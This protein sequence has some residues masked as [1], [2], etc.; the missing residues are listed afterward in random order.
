MFKRVD[1]I[2]NIA[3]ERLFRMFGA[4][5]NIEVVAA[6]TRELGENLEEI[7]GLMQDNFYKYERRMN[8]S[9][10]QI[11]NLKNLYNARKYSM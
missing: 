1:E 3:P 2:G 9:I 10:A 5:P 11:D 8:E 4:D 6:K 7:S